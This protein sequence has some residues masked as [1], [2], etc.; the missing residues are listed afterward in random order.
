MLL[1][2][3]EFQDISLRDELPFLR[4]HRSHFGRD[5]GRSLRLNGKVWRESALHAF[6]PCAQ[7]K[8]LSWSRPIFWFFR[9]LFVFCQSVLCH[10]VCVFHQLFNT[11]EQW[12]SIKIIAGHL[13]QRWSIS[14]FYYRHFV[15]IERLSIAPVRVQWL[16]PF[17]SGSVSESWGKQ[18]KLTEEMIYIASA[19]S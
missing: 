6:R 16:P 18:S 15:P 2:L 14:R 8:L 3:E 1:R 17:F 13:V 12:F 4:R 19:I 11:S 9:P 10:V 7:V 5:R